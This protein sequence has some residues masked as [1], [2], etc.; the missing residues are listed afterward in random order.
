MEVL[1]VDPVHRLVVLDSG[2]KFRFFVA[3]VS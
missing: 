1:G 2:G 3:G